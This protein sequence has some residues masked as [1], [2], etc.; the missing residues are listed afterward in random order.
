MLVVDDDDDLRHLVTQALGRD[1]V[2]CL[3]ATTGEEA[4]AKVMAAP[5]K[6]DAIVLDVCLP[7]MSGVDVLRCLKQKA[8]TAAIPVIMLTATATGE[9]DVVRGVEGGASD[10][11]SKPCSTSV[12]VAKVHAWCERAKAERQLREQLDTAALHAA[13]DALTGLYNRRGF[14]DRL[15]E[16]S[17]HARRHTQPF[18]VLML[19]LDHFKVI[20]DTHGHENGDRVL[21]HF[22]Q[23]LRE[24]LR[25]DDVAF[26][27]GGD[28]F[29]AILHA[30]DARRAMDVATRLK[31]HLRANP[32][33][34]AGGSVWQTTFSGGAA[35]AR[36]SESFAG[37]RLVARA[38]AAL[39]RAK[40]AGR[41]GVAFW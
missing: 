33:R 8:V 24:V 36:A 23:S 21:V 6:I 39:Y 35:S 25:A 1:N 14:E 16:A 27:Y 37:S 32:N 26:R 31:S 5:A 4:L 41:D 3:E 13:C 9:V 17:A 28:E 38:D 40:M 2:S 18:T 22:A 11:L 29:V 19:D 12:L 10:Y 34:F 15:R 7:G 20:N 30:C